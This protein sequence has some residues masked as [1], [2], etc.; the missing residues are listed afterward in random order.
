MDEAIAAIA[1]DR[2][3]SGE[4]WDD[5]CDTLKAAGRIVIR[6]T[7]DGDA[8]DRVEGFRYLTRM[9][10][11]SNMRVIEQMAPTKRQPIAVIPRPMKGGI[12]V[13]SPNQDH[14]V[15]AVD[16][17]YRYRVT[18]KRGDV[19]VHM[20]AWSPP[21]PADVG[22][23]ATGLAAE[24]MLP[25]FNPNNA[26]TPFTAELDEFTDAAGN[27]DFV[28]AV[29]EQ[30][31]PWMPMADTTREL[32]MRVVYEDRSQQS[33]PELEIECLDPHD[34]PE[35]PEPEDMARRLAVGAQLVLGLQADWTREILHY[36]NDLHHTVDTYKR[37]G[38]SPDDR[39]FEF[40]YWRVGPDDAL[41]VEFDPPPNQHWNFQLC[42]H[43]MENL[44]NYF[45]GHG[46]LSKENAVA[47]VDG[48]V[49]IVVS[50]VDPRPDEPTL[51][52][53]DPGDHDHGVMGLR[54]V[55]PEREPEI[56]VRLT[57]LSELQG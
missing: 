47:S 44:A 16:P 30:P 55:R 54:F 43:W 29:D 14:V 38:G 36:E 41:V 28:F 27:V 21:V 56:E 52:H 57:T 50:P 51:N 23:F 22:A 5:F 4:A 12:G 3:M 9:I 26:T 42:N 35:T 33:A 25:D 37:I 34:E 53:V 45:T 49:R 20:S 6:E 48:K 8:G 32:M 2:L 1:H 11:M 15:Q 31:Q 18:G 24:A 17:R 40:G 7:P 10:F 13:Q 39:H 46:Y 19:H